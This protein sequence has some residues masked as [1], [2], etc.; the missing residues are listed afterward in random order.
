MASL[1]LLS[2]SAVYNHLLVSPVLV[3]I[4]REMGVSVGTAGLLVTAYGL[5]GIVVGVLAGP[6]SDRYGRK[7]FL[8]GG[9]VVMSA[10]TLLGA[11]APG[12]AHLLLTRVGA[13]V[14]ASVLFPNMNATVADEFPYQERG[15]AMSTIISL[16]QLAAIVGVPLAGI[17]ASATSWR[18]SFALIGVI[19]LVAAAIVLRTARGSAPPGASD[20]PVRELYAGILADTSVKG[21]MASSLLGSLFW[22]TWITYMVA[23]F[24]ERYGLPTATA[25]LVVLVT[26]VG[27][28]GGSQVGGRL[29]DRFGHRVVVG[30]TIVFA[31]VA[32]LAQTAVVR[33]LWLAA[34]LALA[35][36]LLSGARFAGSMTL[37]SELAPAARGTVLSVNS[38]IV[39]IGIVVGTSVGGVLVDGYGYEA[40]GA[41]ATIAGF[42]S[43]LIVWR[44]VTERAAGFA[45]GE[46]VD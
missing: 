31:G 46:S 44:F 39:S 45:A 14:G 33:E 9:T 26:G 18:V 13:G 22:F 43:A 30:W 36:A 32:L 19:G 11:V 40:L 35:I 27:I 34:V 38:A 5:P 8:V 23:F 20:V 1:G 21:A 37:V 15:R 4:A 3:E 16:N 12:F 28:V 41:M 10:L 24:V 17:I 2:F 7:P 42:A 6:L 25:S 29:G